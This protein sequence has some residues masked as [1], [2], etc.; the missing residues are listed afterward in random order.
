MT[1]SGKTRMRPTDVRIRLASVG[2]F[3]VWANRSRMR[4]GNLHCQWQEGKEGMTPGLFHGISH[5]WRCRSEVFSFGVTVM[6]LGISQSE[7]KAGLDSWQGVRPFRCSWACRPL[8]VLS[9][10]AC[11]G[12]ECWLRMVVRGFCSVGGRCD[13]MVNGAGHWSLCVTAHYD[14]FCKTAIIGKSLS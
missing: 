5:G 4:A 7:K 1:K 10:W 12:R 11:S 2:R 13:F 3:L 6:C 14:Y 8:M 9:P